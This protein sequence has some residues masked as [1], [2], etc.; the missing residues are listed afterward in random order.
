MIDHAQAKIK[1]IESAQEVAKHIGGTEL[2]CMPSHCARL[3]VRLKAAVDAFNA[4][5]QARPIGD[6]DDSFHGTG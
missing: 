5:K 2:A 4:T 6:D 1:L 3:I